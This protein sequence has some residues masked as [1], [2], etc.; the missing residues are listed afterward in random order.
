LD[1]EQPVKVNTSPVTIDF[2]Q[3]KEQNLAVVA[4][5]VKYIKENVQL[6]YTDWINCGFALST[7][8]EGRELFIELSTNKFYNDNVEEIIEKFDNLEGNATGGVGKDSS[9]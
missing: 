7:I 8:P 5:A 3:I 4:A 2:S 9:G 6:D 1:N